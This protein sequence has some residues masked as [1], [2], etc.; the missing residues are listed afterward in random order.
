MLSDEMKKKAN[1]RMIDF[2]LDNDWGEVC[3]N[4]L[5]WMI[6]CVRI[7]HHQLQTTGKLE[8]SFNFTLNFH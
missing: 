3:F 4:D 2:N 6:D 1:F 8:Y 7:N 5:V